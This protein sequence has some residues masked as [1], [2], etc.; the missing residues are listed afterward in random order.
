MDM[1]AAI[2]TFLITLREGVEAA[3]VIGIVLACLTKANASHFYRSVYLGIAAGVFGSVIMGLF[4][5]VGL[6]ALAGSSWPYAKALQ[7]AL[8]G[9]IALLATGLLSWML[10]WMTQQAKGLKAEVET[11][12]QGAIQSN[13]A[14]GI[15]SL[16]FLAVLREGMETVLFIGAQFQAGWLPVIGALAG[17]L[18]ATLMGLLI[19][20]GGVRLN[21]RWFF[22]GMGLFLLLIVAGLLVTALRKLDMSLLLLEQIHPESFWCDTSTNA[23][24]LLGPQVWD[25]S[26]VLPD[27]QFP[28]IILKTFLGYTQRLYAVQAIAY[29]SFL[30]GVG[31]FYWQQIFGSTTKET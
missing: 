22:Q 20:K 16:I 8:Q 9:V 25:L 27:R 11:S 28:G 4:L 17:I 3:L 1:T 31:G 21:L 23:A 14:W 18:G 7:Q 10:L 5:G 29:L 13:T 24:C 26:K 12:V 15:F 30:L 6:Y 19:F 2:P